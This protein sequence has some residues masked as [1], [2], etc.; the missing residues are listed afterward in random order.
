[1]S[2]ADSEVGGW[3]NVFGLVRDESHLPV[4]TI[5]LDELSQCSSVEATYR[6]DMLTKVYLPT[7]T[8]S[9]SVSVNG[10]FGF[11]S[12]PPILL[13]GVLTIEAAGTERLIDKFLKDFEII[14]IFIN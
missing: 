11:F 3:D 7:K 14:F 10:I 2:M 6:Y 8:T 4:D 5:G 9:K 1:M 12:P 13:W